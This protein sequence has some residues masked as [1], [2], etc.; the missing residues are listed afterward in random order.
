M[1]ACEC[2]EHVLSYYE[3]AHGGDPRPRHAI[4]I[5]RAWVHGF[6][7]VSE[8]RGAALAAHAAAREA[9]DPSA[10]AAARAAGHA[11][12]TAHVERHARHAATYA[13]A[14]V[15]SAGDRST[16]S[17]AVSMERAWQADRLPARLRRIAFPPP[18][19]RR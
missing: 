3:D 18:P 12:A 11:A 19:S 4:E 6:A 1:W 14:A 16:A 13:V 5:G 17:I 7:S 10:R 2:A 9:D 8:A 15:R